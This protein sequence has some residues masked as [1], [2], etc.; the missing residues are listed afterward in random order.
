M[1]YENKDTGK[2]KI[3]IIDDVEVNRFIL[4]E[5]VSNMGC[6]PVLAESGKQALDKIKQSIPQLILTDISMPEMDGYE[7]CRILKS[8]EETKNIPIVFIS[9]F[10]DPQDIVEGLFLGG[11][12]YI[13]KPFIPEVVQA[14]VGVHLRLHDAKQKLMEMN[15]R[16][17]VSVNEQLKQMEQEKKNILSA[18]ANI[19]IRNLDYKEEYLERL[20]RNCRTLALAMQLSPIFEDKVSDTFIDAIELAAPLCDIG[21]FGIPKEILQKKTEFTKEEIELIHNHTNIGAD[22][23]KELYVNNDYND[24]VSTAIDIVQYHH[25]NWNGSGYPKGLS[26]EDIP[27]GAQIVSLVERYCTLT[28][29]KKCSREDALEKMETEAGVKFNP[30]I[31]KICSKILRQLC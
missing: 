13:T 9:A 27:L 5:I 28:D 3:L 31:Y 21:N 11:E 19:V 16:L 30:E 8:K 7:L 29:S 26:K 25:E 23:L 4:E 17:Q 18:L 15:R 2:D 20:K 12:D 10:D 1:D 14:R 22:F 6:C 24:F